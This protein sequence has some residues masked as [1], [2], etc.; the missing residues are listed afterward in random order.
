MQASTEKLFLLAGG[1][2]GLQTPNQENAH[3]EEESQNSILGN[4]LGIDRF[5]E[6]FFPLLLEQVE[7]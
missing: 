2:R 6:F 1:R 5:L 7:E 4:G 3:T